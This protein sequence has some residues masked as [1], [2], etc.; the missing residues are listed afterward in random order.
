[1]TGIRTTPFTNGLT[2]NEPVQNHMTPVVHTIGKQASLSE[3]RRAMNDR[4][5]RHLPVMHRG[6]L[7]GIVSLRDI[8][9]LE[10]LDDVDS[11][12]VMV[13]EAMSTDV[14]V[15][16]PSAS[17]ASVARTMASRKLG[18]ALVTGGGQVLGI[19][20]TV[21]ALRALAWA[22]AG[23]DLAPRRRGGQRAVAAKRGKGRRAKT[24][25]QRSR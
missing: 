2:M 13:E 3:A 5:I 24:K 19:F 8:E 1:L 10:T 12:T 15:V 22:L 25:G 16:G 18:S 23:E 20:T 17:L 4:R 9:L 6:D 11:D 14:F 21:D 7:I